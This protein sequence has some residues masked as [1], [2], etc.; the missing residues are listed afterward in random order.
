MWSIPP[1]Q[2]QDEDGHHFPGRKYSFVTDSA[3][4]TRITENLDLR[5]VTSQFGNSEVMLL[6][7]LCP[8][9]LTRFFLKVMNDLNGLWHCA[10]PTLA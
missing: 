7:M 2:D 8:L 10:G 6:L 1:A 4:C 9:N 5:I 3:L